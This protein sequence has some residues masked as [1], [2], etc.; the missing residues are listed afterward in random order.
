[1]SEIQRLLLDKINSNQSL[2]DNW[3]EEK[4]SAKTPLIYNSVDL[5]HSGF[6]IVPVDNNC[7]PAGFNNLNKDSQNL[8]SKFIADFLQK[9]HP[10]AKKILIVPENH[11]R[12]LKYLENVLTLRSIL[13]NSGSEVEI[14]SLIE[15]LEDD[16]I[17]DLEETTHKIILHKLLKKDGKIITKSGFEP[18]LI[19][20]NNDFTNAP[21]EILHNIK[22]EIIP[23]T[24]IGWHKRTKSRHFDIYKNL[25]TELAN[26]INIDVWLIN[27]LH[28]NCENIDFKN[29]NGVENLASSVDKI[30]K[31]IKEK[32]QEYNITDAPY[33]Y[34]KA[35]SGT[36]GMA[37]MTIHDP[38]EILQIN[39]KQRNKMNMI[40]GNVLNHRVIIQE[41]V[42]TID[43]INNIIAE[44]MIYLA[45]GKVAGHLFRNN[46]QR[47][48]SISL[49]AAGMLLGD[50]N[51]ISD[52]NLVIG[53]DRK[54]IFTIYDLVARLSTLAAANEI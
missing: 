7:F 18:D 21:E 29:R 33:C 49:N 24:Q 12:N 13:E 26:L 20:S 50:M 19:I 30:L 43:T 10:N 41:G 17:I 22:Q 53:G 37:M 8:A 51:D 32:Y 44:P 40:K 42:K 52:E 15:N 4:F 36:Y 31:E 39:K 3:F 35:D 28:T 34:V 11:T 47:D 9:Y 6:K 38:E 2:I 5:R 48:S 27:A 45:A 14:G 1:M 54:N 23:S 46:D 25:A 16:L